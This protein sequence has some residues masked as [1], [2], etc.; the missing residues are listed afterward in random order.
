LAIP[1]ADRPSMAFTVCRT[2]PSSRKMFTT[3]RL[4]RE[5]L[6]ALLEACN[7]FLVPGVP[8][9]LMDARYAQFLKNG[10]PVISADYIKSFLVARREFILSQIPESRFSVDGT[11]SLVTTN[12]VL[13]ISGLAPVN[14]SDV[15]IEGRSVA[16]NWST[17]TNWAGTYRL[18]PGTNR[19]VVRALDGNGAEVTNVTVTAVLNGGAPW[20][21]LRINE[22]L[23]DNAG[24]IRDPAD[25]D[26]D[27][28][29]ELFNPTASAV[30]LTG[31]SLTDNLANKTQF[32]IPSGYSVPARGFALVWADGETG[33]NA[34]GAN[35][36]VNFNSASMVTRSVCSRPMAS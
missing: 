36:H 31:W 26:A 19:L 18:A 27:D 21:A 24:I 12:P 4:Q 22:W 28:W 1:K 30:D 2:I 3:P 16:Q 10:L 34:P 5:Y 15:V 13:A 33:Q 7:T 11:N 23:A 20:P 6:G 9:V 35:L 17:L 25:G 8:D 32:V 29:F 14:A